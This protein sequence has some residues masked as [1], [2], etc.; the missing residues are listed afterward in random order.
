MRAATFTFFNRRDPCDAAL[1]A[2]YPAA[3]AAVAATPPF[4][5]YSWAKRSCRSVSS[6][7]PAV[8]WTVPIIDPPWSPLSATPVFAT[9]SCIGSPLLATPA[10]GGGPPALQLAGVR[11]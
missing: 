7:F 4:A 1:A 11:L 10:L 9:D 2:L 8:F 5:L 3:A 6:L